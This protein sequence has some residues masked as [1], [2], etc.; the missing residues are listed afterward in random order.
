MGLVDSFAAED[1]VEVKYSDFYELVRA[2]A[3]RALLKNAVFAGVPREQILKML[4]GQNDELE[5]YRKTGL[6]PDQIREMDKFYAEKCKEVAITTA[7]KDVLKKQI[8]DLMVQREAEEA[9]AEGVVAEATQGNETD[10]E[11]QDPDKKKPRRRRDIDK[12]KILA[13][14]KAGWKVKDIAEDMGL[15]ASTV[16]QVLWQENRKAKQVGKD[17]NENA[18]L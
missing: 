7:E 15:E 6:S 17:E 14:K 1:R 5:E 2:E 3:E 9:A 10:L 16:S 18:L 12:G 13:L 11:G 4:S 8:E